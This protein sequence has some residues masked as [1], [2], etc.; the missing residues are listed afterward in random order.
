MADHLTKEKRSWNMSRIRSKETAPE[1]AFRKLIYR[2]GFRYRLYDKTLPGKPDLVMKKHKII[3]FIHG[4]F[5]HGHENCRRGNKPKTHKKYWNAK[6]KGNVA[7]DRKNITTLENSGWRVFAVWE[8]ELKDLE[9]VLQ[10]FKEFVGTK[11]A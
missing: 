6:I 3:V 4:C 10:K 8:C 2:A 7:R 9:T 1:I 5:W 11:D